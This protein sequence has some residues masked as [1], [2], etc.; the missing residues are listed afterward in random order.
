MVSRIAAFGSAS[1]LSFLAQLGVRKPSFV[2]FS[3]MRETTLLD[4]YLETSSNSD[5]PASHWLLYL[6][7]SRTLHNS[8]ER[9]VRFHSRWGQ[10]SWIVQFC[11]KYGSSY[12]W[13]FACGWHTWLIERFSWIAPRFLRLL[14]ACILILAQ[15]A[16]SS[17]PHILCGSFTKTIALSSH[18]ST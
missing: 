17:L 1:T 18:L 10:L 12:L 15:A 9:W 14:P 11:L 13:M 4:K 16:R 7:Y 8:I 2:G 3:D 6:L 5:Y